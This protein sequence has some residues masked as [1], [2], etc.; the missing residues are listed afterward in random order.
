MAYP[1]FS[2]SLIGYLA[3]NCEILIS[4]GIYEPTILFIE[5]VVLYG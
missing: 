4:A 2:N 1:N 5:V 3:S